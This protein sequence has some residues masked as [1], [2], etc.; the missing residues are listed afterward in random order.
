VCFIFDRQVNVQMKTLISIGSI[1]IGSIALNLMPVQQVQAASLVSNGDFNT[2]NV[3]DSRYLGGSNNG[4]TA[5]TATDW[6]FDPGGL[7]WLVKMGTTY[8]QNLNLDQNNT[9]LTQKM[10]G[11]API[12]SP[13]GT[14]NWYIVADGD[15]TYARTISQSISGLEVGSQYAVSFYQ[16]AGQQDSFTGGTTE[17]WDVSFG[18]TTQS[19]TVMSP[20]QPYGPGEDTF[21]KKQ[22]ITGGTATAVSSW[23]QET[24][25]FTADA[26][27]STLSFLAKGTPSGKPPFSLLTGVGVNKI[28]E[29]ADYV[30]TL[31]GFGFVGLAIKSRLAKKKLD[32]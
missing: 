11:T 26:S 32:E 21:K 24:M 6:T 13:N 2:N 31:V 17:R 8:T 15:P 27:T 10:Y 9:D 23:Q 18:G 12:T 5:A 1:A 20:V 29:P 25:I 14:A 3:T 4:I 7:T 22:Q 19:S 28:P 16:A 30:G